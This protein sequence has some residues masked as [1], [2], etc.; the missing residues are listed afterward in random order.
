MATLSSADLRTAL[1]AAGTWHEAQSLPELAT[2][3]VETLHEL[4][5]CDGVGWN[6]VDLS[7]GR[8]H[9]VTSPVDFFVPETAAAL[10]RL[11]D[12]HPIVSYVARTGDQ[13]ATKIS[14]FVSVREFHRLE[15]YADF[16]RVLECE[17]LLAVIVQP[18]PVIVG[19]AFTRPART[20]AERDRDLLNLVRPHLSA[21]Y[22]NIAARAEALE[23][24]ATVERGLNG[25]EVVPL[26]SAGR[27]A[28]VS[29]LVQRWFGASGAAIEP[30][31]YRRDDAELTVRRVDGDPPVLL[32]DERR[33]VPDPQRVREL[34]LTRRES[35]I[36]ALAARGLT[37]AQIA[38]TLFLSGRTVSKHMQHAFEKLGVHS[39]ADAAD[40]LLTG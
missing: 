36:V 1:A 10:D 18:E 28:A 3:A 11:I 13:S 40:R 12:Q 34:G 23:R 37:D 19:L 16:F 32:L 29:P 14:D 38:D 7:N 26:D 30:G 8:V 6:E 25:R 2:V 39:R 20:Y 31:T 22:R 35:E 17:D 9:A 24:L 4:V 5:S 27:I 21:A 15:I 33:Y